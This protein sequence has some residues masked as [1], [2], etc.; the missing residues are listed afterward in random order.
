MRR[1]IINTLILVSGGLATL[2]FAG[3][4]DSTYNTIAMKNQRVEDVRYAN[5]LLSAWEGPY[6]GIPPFDRVSVG[7]FKP[8]LEAAMAENLAE[9]DKITANTAAATFEN[10]IEAMERAGKTLDRVQTIYNIWG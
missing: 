1:A 3:F 6:G 7:D 9:I 2:A 8:A 4:K 10:T 5:P